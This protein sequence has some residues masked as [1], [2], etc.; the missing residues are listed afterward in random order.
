MLW[1]QELE[2]GWGSREQKVERVQE[3]LLWYS[4][5]FLLHA[6]LTLPIKT[7]AILQDPIL[8]ICDTPDPPAWFDHLTH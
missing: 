6:F 2:V 3:T 1:W 5:S 7:L 4:T 8:H